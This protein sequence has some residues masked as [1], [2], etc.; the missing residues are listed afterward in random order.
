MLHA[1]RML[2]LLLLTAEWGGVRC[3]ALLS[4]FMGNMISI[5]CQLGHAK[6]PPHPK[7]TQIKNQLFP[8][9][10]TPYM[11]LRVGSTQKLTSLKYSVTSPQGRGVPPGRDRGCQNTCFDVPF[12][13]VY[14]SALSREQWRLALSKLKKLLV[15]RLSAYRL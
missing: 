2:L 7:H 6:I 12:A 1:M 5:L 9:L 10:E 11:Y 8:F 14:R 15:I 3:A 13:Y 4:N